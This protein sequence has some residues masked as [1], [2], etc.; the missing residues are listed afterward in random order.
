MILETFATSLRTEKEGKKGEFAG[1]SGDVASLA[2]YFNVS[3]QPI[4]I[5]F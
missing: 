2:I 1:G 3:K 5:I 4:G